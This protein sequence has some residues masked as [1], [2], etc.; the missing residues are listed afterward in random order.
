MPKEIWTFSLNWSYFRTPSAAVGSVLWAAS[1]FFYL[2]S[3]SLLDDEFVNYESTKNGG[4]A[5]AA[6]LICKAGKIQFRSWYCDT[7]DW[8]VN[9]SLRGKNKY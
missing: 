6:R 2:Q 3:L 7:R 9:T 1:I 8:P 5:S 4:A